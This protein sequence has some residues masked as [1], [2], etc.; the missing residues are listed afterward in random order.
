MPN[1]SAVFLSDAL[2]HHG[3]RPRTSKEGWWTAIRVRL[4]CA[5]LQTKLETKETTSSKAT[6][7]AVNEDTGVLK[8]IPRN[9]NGN[10][11]P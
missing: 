8:N 6:V 11:C 9:A 10:E 2:G 1:K 3:D 5:D 4:V 7:S